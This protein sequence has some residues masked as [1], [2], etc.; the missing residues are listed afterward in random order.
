MKLDKIAFY[1][2][3]PQ[4]VLM[5]K[6]SLGLENVHWIT[7]RVTEDVTFNALGV[8]GHAVADLNINFD[9]GIEVEFLTYRSGPHWHLNKERFK[10]GEMFLSHIGFH[11]EPGEEVPARGP[12]IQEMM[13]VAHTNDFQ[14]KTGRR[15]RSQIYGNHDLIRKQYNPLGWPTMG[16]DF[17]YIWRIEKTAGELK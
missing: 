15:Y 16:A 17:K 4:Q 5:G 13:S 9:L 7:D 8:I 3:T 10:N 11:M 2:H 12:L 14:V 1:A 6:K